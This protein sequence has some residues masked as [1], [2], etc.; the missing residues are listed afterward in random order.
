MV[1]NKIMKYTIFDPQ[2]V[3]KVVDITT[4]SIEAKKAVI[5]SKTG[6]DVIELKPH[7]MSK[8]LQ[9]FFIDEGYKIETF[10]TTKR[11]GLKS[12]C[13]FEVNVLPRNHSNYNGGIIMTFVCTGEDQKDLDNDI[14][15]KTN[16]IMGYFTKHK[17]PLDR[18]CEE[19]LTGCEYK[20]Y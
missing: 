7:M 4:E 14:R 9:Q 8:K 12:L 19:S 2:Y 3:E 18:V 1:V 16:K 20:F 13:G 15:I 17:I 10:V 11:R 6:E 5:K